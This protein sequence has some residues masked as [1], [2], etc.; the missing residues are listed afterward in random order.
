LNCQFA[1][2]CYCGEY[3]IVEHTHIHHL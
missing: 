2:Y 3:A 1:N